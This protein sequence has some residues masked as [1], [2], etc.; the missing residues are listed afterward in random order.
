MQSDSALSLINLNICSK[1]SVIERAYRAGNCYYTTLYSYEWK[2]DFHRSSPLLSVLTVL[3]L[4]QRSFSPN[5][6]VEKRLSSIYKSIH[7]TSQFKKTLSINYIYSTIN[8]YIFME[9]S[10]KIYFIIYMNALIKVDIVGLDFR[11]SCEGGRTNTKWWTWRVYLI[12]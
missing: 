8:I 7:G 1:I 3:V 6:Y 5:L 4:C 11:S 9:V 12:S 10:Y 2:R